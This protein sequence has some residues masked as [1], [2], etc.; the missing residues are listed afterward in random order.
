MSGSG[1]PQWIELDLGAEVDVERLV[2]W[3]DQDPGG[4]TDHRVLGGLEPDPTDEL[5]RLSGDTDWGQRLEVEIGRTV[6]YLR[7]ET[8]AS[9]SWVAWLEILVISAE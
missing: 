5:A 7:V 6:R 2:L 1:A 4:F 3:V 8:V 9:P